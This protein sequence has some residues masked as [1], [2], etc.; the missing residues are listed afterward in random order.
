M[1]TL[2]SLS[3][4]MMSLIFIFI[5]ISS[6]LILGIISSAP[7][8]SIMLHGIFS[9]D[10]SIVVSNFYGEYVSAEP[11]TIIC[12]CAEFLLFIFSVVS[13]FIFLRKMLKLLFA[14]ETY[15][16]YLYDV[17]FLLA[18]LLP[19]FILM[20]CA[21]FNFSITWI[22]VALCFMSIVIFMF[23]IL[24]L[25]KIGPDSQVADFRKHMF[26]EV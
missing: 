12:V 20:L 9:E 2:L 19:N 15:I 26:E 1:K 8:L 22:F 6:F 23:S 14:G 18:L 17:F 24:I 4:L 11:V 21:L 3:N 7:L 13:I 5:L 16:R 10:P 25:K